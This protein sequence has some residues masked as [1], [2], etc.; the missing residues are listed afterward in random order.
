M[1]PSCRPVGGSA[2]LTAPA[3]DLNVE[4]FGVRASAS[5][6]TLKFVQPEAQGLSFQ[7]FAPAIT[8]AKLS[9]EVRNPA[10]IRKQEESS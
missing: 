4:T 7:R 2:K 10:Q 3:I 1:T 9:S 5:L 8:F 6:P